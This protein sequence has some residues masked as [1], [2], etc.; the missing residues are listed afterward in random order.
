MKTI[1]ETLEQ[2]LEA[3]EKLNNTNSHW[4][5]EVDENV[6]VQLSN[7]E[8]ALREAL[9]EQKSGIKQVIELYDSPD[10]PSPATPLREQEPIGCEGAVVNGRVYA[11]RLEHEYKFECEAGPLH[12]CTEWVEFRRCFEWLAQ[13][14]SPPPQRKPLT[15]EQVTDGCRT[16]GVGAYRTLA[17]AFEAGVRFAEAAHGIKEQP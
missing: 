5:Q 17:A 4:W 15:D 12:L 1:K 8:S 9:S 6:I 3:L 2:A 7:A 11:D 13:H 10:Q 14:T 16:L